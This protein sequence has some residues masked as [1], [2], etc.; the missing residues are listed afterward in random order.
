MAV[1]CLNAVVRGI[2]EPEHAE[3]LAT[4]EGHEGMNHALKT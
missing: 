3:E 4:Q 1:I 2:S